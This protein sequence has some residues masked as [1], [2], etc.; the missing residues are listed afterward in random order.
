[1][2]MNSNVTI[3]IAAADGVSRLA[4]AY[5]TPPF[6]VAN[7]TEDKRGPFL[8]L[9]LMCSSPGVLDGD[10]QDFR[11][12]LEAH[13]RLRLHTQAYQ[14]LFHMKRGATQCM[15]VRVGKG[16]CFCWLPHPCVPHAE[17]IFTAR[18]KVFLEEGAQLIWGEVLTCGR[19]LSGEIFAL[20]SYHTRTEIFVQERLV[21][22]ENVYLRPSVMPV[23]ALGQ[24]EGFTHQASLLFVEAG[25]QANDERRARIAAFLQDRTDLIYGVSQ[26]PANS[27]IVRLL[28]HH[29]EPLYECLKTMQSILCPQPLTYAS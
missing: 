17:S 24:M 3:R 28:G 1:M 9:M 22:L 8:E 4:S 25:A 16:A 14:R 18:N 2:A 23:R 19:K 13:S 5:Y 26:G 7:I 21:L 11:V 10:E 20:S 29:A 6:K 15:E 27:I 12:E